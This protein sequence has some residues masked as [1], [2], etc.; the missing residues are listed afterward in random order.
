MP[1]KLIEIIKLEKTFILSEE[2]QVRAI[3]GIS[4]DIA[5]GEYIAIM[6]A[7]GSG[8]STFM[9]ILGF[10]DTPTAG[11]YLLDGI[12]AGILDSDQKAEIRNKKI[13]F[14]FQG[15]NLL[16]RTSALENVELPL[17]YKGDVTSD[18]LSNKAHQLLARV[19]LAGREEHHPNKLSGGEQQRVAIARAL[20]NDPAIILADEPTG[21]L[22][23]HNTRDI[24]ELFTRLNK[25]IGITIIMVTH[26]HDVADYTDRKVIFRDGLIVDDF[27]VKKSS[28]QQSRGKRK[29]A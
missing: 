7:S 5:R 1:E 16:A 23:T 20:I 15:F 3:K 22:D 9:N 8:K 28:K 4:L 6:G 18:E 2:V 12:D 14:V 19:G 10:L 29:L 13:G 24:M 17:F 21:N 26:E 25:E 27:K 11:S